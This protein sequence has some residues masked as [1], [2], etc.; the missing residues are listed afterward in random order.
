[1]E[2]ATTRLSDADAVLWTL[3]RDPTLRSPITAVAVLDREASYDD[4]LERFRSLARQHLHFRSVVVPSSLPWRNPRWQ[5]CDPFDA[6]DHL[7]HV[8]VALPGDVR[9]VLD[10]AQSMA[11]VAFDPVRP[12]GRPS[13]STE[14]PTGG[15]P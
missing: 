6:A 2:E 3:D 14:W 1:M 4:L 12:R 7:R 15:R 8:R 13:W 10:L 5:E 11:L 9:D